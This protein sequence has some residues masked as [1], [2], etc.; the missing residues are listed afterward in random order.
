MLAILSRM[1]YTA[2]MLGFFL[3]K[4]FFDGWDNLF[5]LVFLNAAFIALACAAFFLPPLFGAGS[6]LAYAV[7]A[8][9]LLASS[10]WWAACVE[11]VLPVADYG[12]VAWREVPA[13]LK[14]ALIP[15]LQYGALNLVLLAA[16]VV[17]LPFYLSRG[18]FA[19]ALAGGILLWCY[20]I[21]VLAFQW[22]LPLR[23][24]LGGGFV[25][26]LKKCLFFFFDNAFFS[27]FVFLYNT[28]GLAISAFLALL[29]PG[30]AGLAL[31]LDDALRVRLL[32]YD[33]LEANPGEKRS[34][35]PWDALLVEER[36]LVGK[37][38]LK[39]MIFPWKE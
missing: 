6:L 25:K 5:S 17:G 18:G 2:S 36:E 37:R 9:T 21:F 27:I 38:T 29:A 39:G 19:S 11:A 10:V 28:V 35:V 33:W 32:K 7:L 8:L 24:R 1:G 12:R 13:L 14:K 20:V 34:A 16:L 4:A 3:K 26:N 15:G 31:A 22:Y 23:A 30:F